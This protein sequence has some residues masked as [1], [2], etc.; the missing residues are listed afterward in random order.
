MTLVGQV[1][2]TNYDSTD[3]TSNTAFQFSQF[4]ENQKNGLYD[5]NLNDPIL[6]S[7]DPSVIADP[8][9]NINTEETFTGIPDIGILNG[10]T[11]INFADSVDV[12][13]IADGYQFTIEQSTDVRITLDGLSADADLGI[14]SPSGE[15]LALSENLDVA[16]EVLEGNLAA[17]TYI[18]GVVAYEG[19]ETGYDLTVSTGDFALSSV[20]TDPGFAPEFSFI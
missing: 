12:T 7:N 17:G 15:L 2:N 10:D 18:L 20:E 19:A 11:S 5:D 4:L 13:N 1:G 8:T 14:L 16:S 9:I 3:F 6:I